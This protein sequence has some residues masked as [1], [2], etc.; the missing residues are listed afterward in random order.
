MCGVDR[1]VQTGFCAVG[2]APTVARAALHFFEE[3]CISG[4]RG[5]GTVFF[6]GC[7]LRC[8]FCQNETISRGGGGKVVTP[9]RLREIYFELIDKG[10][11]NINLVTPS[12]FADAV[13]E[14]LEGGLPVPVVWNCGGY[15]RVE[16]LRKLEGKVQI[17]LPDFKYAD[18]SLAAKLSAAPDYP[19]VAEAALAEMYRQT[20]DFAPDADGMLR[21]G[22]LIRH[23]VLP[24]HLANTFGVIDRVRRLFP[25]D[26]QVLFSLMS[27]YTPV[28]DLPQYPE[29]C[30]RLTE[31]E[32]AAAEQ[33]LFD[34]GIEDG[35][36]QDRTSAETD[37]IPVFDGTGV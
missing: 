15:E 10:A 18:A 34:S 21:S 23:L 8:V 6:T 27:Q 3:P 14:S 11:H 26:G 24:G 4:T 35:F 7:N 22:V 2:S 13:A 19:A 31:E 9:Q 12:H 29:L 36:V 16:T 28:V 33:A 32:Y 30:R 37:Y 5:S 25:R 1:A 20:G 17:Y